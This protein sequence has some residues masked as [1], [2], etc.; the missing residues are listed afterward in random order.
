MFRQMKFSLELK[1]FVNF[2][3]VASYLDLGGGYMHPPQM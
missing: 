1:N 3:R 2:E